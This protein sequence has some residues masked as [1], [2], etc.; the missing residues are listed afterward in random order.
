MYCLENKS[1]IGKK[2]NMKREKKEKNSSQI[3]Q[4]RLPNSVLFNLNYCPCSLKDY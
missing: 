2:I 4:I 3:Y 1:L